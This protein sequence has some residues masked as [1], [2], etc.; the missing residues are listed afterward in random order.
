MPDLGGDVVTRPANDRINEHRGPLSLEDGDDP[1]LGLR[2]HPLI[3]AA[4]AMHLLAQADRA[5]DLGNPDHRPATSDGC[6][7][8]RGRC[9]RA[10][11]A[12]RAG[13]CSGS[14]ERRPRPGARTVVRSCCAAGH[15]PSPHEDVRALALRQQRLV[16]IGEEE[17]WLDPSACRP[18][19]LALTICPLASASGSTTRMA[20]LTWREVRCG[21]SMA[22]GHPRPDP[23]PGTC[24]RHGLAPVTPDVRSLNDRAVASPATPGAR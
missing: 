6:A 18:R 5:A 14:T 16:Q 7:A 11:S 15:H 19:T 21:S 24:W 20:R 22:L 2:H 13:P 8:P 12:R 17:R 3:D 10:E 4:H 9:S 23:I 1:L